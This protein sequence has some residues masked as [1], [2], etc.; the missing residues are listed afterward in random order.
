MSQH[1]YLFT[2]LSDSFARCCTG[3]SI[4]CEVGDSRT[5][6][7][8]FCSRVLKRQ[9]C[10][11]Q[12]RSPTTRNPLLLV[13]SSLRTSPERT[14]SRLTLAV[15]SKMAIEILDQE[16]GMLIIW[17]IKH[18]GTSGPD[19]FRQV[20]LSLRYAKTI[21]EAWVTFLQ[22]TDR[23]IIIHPLTQPVSTT[24]PRIDRKA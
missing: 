15:I 23:L 14:W 10:V 7:L 24:S 20:L 3:Q 18:I 21:G 22:H 5:A 1:E 8:R 4:V 17:S 2:S 19:V 9:L 6:V 11:V 12:S 16:T 13:Y